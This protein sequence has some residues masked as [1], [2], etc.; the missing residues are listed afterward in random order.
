MQDYPKLVTDGSNIGFT[1]YDVWY[2]YSPAKNNMADAQKCIEKG[3]PSSGAAEAEFNFY[4]WTRKMLDIAGFSFAE[5][6]Q[7]NDM[8]SQMQ[9]P[10][11]PRVFLD[12][13]YAITY[14]ELKKNY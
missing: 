12:P 9:F 11:W 7:A 8:N 4:N 2:C 1:T 6:E 3:I 10:Y 14:Q 13:K 5:S